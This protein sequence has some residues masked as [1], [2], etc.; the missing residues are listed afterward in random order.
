MKSTSINKTQKRKHKQKHI[1]FK[2]GYMHIG[3]TRWFSI[4]EHLGYEQSRRDD[5]ERLGYI[6]VYFL[7]QGKLPWIGLKLPCKQVC[8]ICFFRSL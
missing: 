4:K 8:T 5:L 2:T 3:D 7:N 1:P 6:L